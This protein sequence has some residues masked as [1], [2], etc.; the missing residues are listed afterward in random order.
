MDTIT[1]T[2]TAAEGTLATGTQRG[3]LAGQT[4]KAHG[5]RWG[6]SISCWFIRGS[7]DHLPREHTIQRAKAALESVGYTVVVE[8]DLA[9]RPAEQVWA[10][11]VGR[12][13]DRVEALEGK[14]ARKRAAGET[15][16]GEVGDAYSNIP[17]GQ[18]NIVDGRGRSPL[19]NYRDR[20]HTK[21]DRGHQARQ[22]GAEAARRAGAAVA[23]QSYRES[24]PAT[25]RRIQHREAEI[26]LLQRQLDGATGEHLQLTQARLAQAQDL[27]AWDVQHLTQL[28]EDGKHHT[29]SSADFTKGDYARV[30]GLWLLVVG[31]NS[32]S[33]TVPDYS[34]SHTRTA[35]YNSV[36][37]CRAAVEHLG[38]LAGAQQAIT[39]DLAGL[40][41]VELPVDEYTADYTRGLAG[42]RGVFTD[43]VRAGWPAPYW[44]LR[45]NSQGSGE[46]RPCTVADPPTG[47]PPLE[48][49]K[50][51]PG[52]YRKESR[53]GY[54]AR[55]GP[56]LDV[57]HAMWLRR[58]AT[59]TVMGRGRVPGVQYHT[60]GPAVIVKTP[61]ETVRRI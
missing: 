26:R 15:I 3:D 37:G 51:S 28:N 9:H 33:V 25:E 52:E 17:L 41:P 12:S 42:P 7:R 40:E 22:E 6:R 43:D 27:L 50:L 20:L 48:L 45:Q 59:H 21:E 44:V 38:L 11:Q 35:P 61:T 13:A 32:R 39:P 30:S 5:F 10:D 23:H 31:V 55:L 8:V 47:E 4:L 49:L 16:L 56:V 60:Y 53:G 54:A 34:G 19:R 29:W 2:H 1:I 14:A 57:Q 58:G 36:T 24:G 18:P 46:L